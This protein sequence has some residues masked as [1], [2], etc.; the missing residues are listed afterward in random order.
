[1]PQNWP[2][3][4]I[5]SACSVKKRVDKLT[6]TIHQLKY[7]IMLF[8]AVVPAPIAEIT[9]AAPVTASPPA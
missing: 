7:S 2:F 4:L 1:M 9:V 6:F 5:L 8:A 3:R